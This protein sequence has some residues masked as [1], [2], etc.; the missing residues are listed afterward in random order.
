MRFLGTEWNKR[1]TTLLIIVLLQLIALLSIIYI[2]QE[3]T[4]YEVKFYKEQYKQCI[5]EI[6]FFNQGYTNVW[7]EPINVLNYT[8]LDTLANL[9]TQ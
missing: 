2:A 8:Q 9:T 5:D 1:E 3:Q 7:N 6:N 4:K